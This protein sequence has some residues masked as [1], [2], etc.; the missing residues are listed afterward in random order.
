MKEDSV[1]T[2]SRVIDRTHFSFLKKVMLELASE[3]R[4]KRISWC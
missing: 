1:C 3:W 4:R 2:D